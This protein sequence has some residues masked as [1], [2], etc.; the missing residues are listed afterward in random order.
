[1]DRKIIIVGKTASG[2]DFLLKEFKKLPEYKIGIKHTTRPMR[3][4]EI[5]GVTYH[6]TCNT[7]FNLL[8]E[9]KQI[10]IYQDFFMPDAKVW[11]YGFTNNTLESS[12]VLMFTP[13]ELTLLSYEQRKEFIVIYLD[14][15]IDIRRERLISRGDNNDS[16]ERR[17]ESD[18]KD[19]ANFVD[20]DIKILDP[21]FTFDDVID[22]IFNI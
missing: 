16:I 15:P 11:K 1:M 22:L 9:N 17:L 6:Y 4:G 5:E 20:C 18:E 2:K 19:F 3:N 7:V 14:I 12:N 8:V 21:N 13:Y 10:N